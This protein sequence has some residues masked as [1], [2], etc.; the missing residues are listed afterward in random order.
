[1]SEEERVL[2]GIE[3]DSD[4]INK[5]TKNKINKKLTLKVHR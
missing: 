2:I 4:I 1:M 5:V 3:N